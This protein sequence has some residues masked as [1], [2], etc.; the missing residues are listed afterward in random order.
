MSSDV[1]PRGPA[2]SNVDLALEAVRDA[3]VAGRLRPGERIKE[4][5]LAEELGF[6]RAPVRDAL[7]LLE[8]DGLVELVPNRGGVVP[9]LRAGDLLEVYGVGDSLGTLALHQLILD[10]GFL[11]LA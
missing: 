10:S 7:R 11:E 5:P 6:S 1:R 4:I 2:P 3:I 8:R 9:G